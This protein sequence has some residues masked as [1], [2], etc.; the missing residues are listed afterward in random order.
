MG[1]DKI[2]GWSTHGPE[3]LQEANRLTDILDYVGCGP[4]FATQTKATAVPV[5]LEYVTYANE[6]AALPFVAIGGIKEHN[7]TQV[8]GAGADTV[9]V[10]SEI[11][12][13]EDIAGKVRKLA[14]L[15]R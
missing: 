15:M 7:I 1:P 11:T 6:H 9:C 4:V 2:I 13:A 12:G 10:V 8:R 3:Q 5:G 14:E